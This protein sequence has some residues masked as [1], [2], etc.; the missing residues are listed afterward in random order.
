M[1]KK[2]YDIMI[3]WIDSKIGVT[4]KGW[5]FMFKTTLLGLEGIGDTENNEQYQA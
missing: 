1:L 4:F 2:T 5:S 3:I